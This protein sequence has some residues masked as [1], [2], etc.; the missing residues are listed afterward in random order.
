MQSH[1]STHWRTLQKLSTPTRYS[2]PEMRGLHLWVRADLKKYWIFRFTFDGSRHD[3]SLGS[4]PAVSLLDATK[5]ALKLRGQLFNGLNPALVRQHEKSQRVQTAKKITFRKFA[6]SYIEKRSPE[7]SSSKSEYDWFTTIE[8]FAN[9]VIG[10]LD[11]RYIST[12]QVLEIL[13]PIW[14]TKHVTASRLRGR[15]ER[16][17]SA[18]ITSGYMNGPNPA[19]WNGHLQNLLPRIKREVTH[20]NALPYQELPVLFAQLAA[21]DSIASI[22]L[23]F[24]ILN[25][26]RAG[27]TVQAEK[28]QIID[29]IWTIPADRMKARREHQ[30]P[31]SPQA[32]ELI[33]RVNKIYPESLSFFHTPTKRFHSV[34]MLRLLR[35]LNPVATTHGFRSAFRDWVSEETTHNPEV[36]EMALAHTIKNKVEAAYR[37]GK[38]LER[39]KSLM[40][41]WANFCTTQLPTKSS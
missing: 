22:A 11:L 16:I 8:T 6:E 9:P 41:D 28:I 38:L 18:A 4:F 25:A 14:A 32:L 39:R 24:T 31:L 19:A 5:R 30:I 3:M 20:L 33:D 36:A 40:I 12:D 34:F 10:D 23:Q 17:F 21:D 29:G 7:W 35:K 26:C 13:N 1:K 37:R 15:L 2:I 27:E